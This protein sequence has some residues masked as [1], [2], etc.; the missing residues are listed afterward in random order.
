ME[1]R[2]SRGTISV[3]LGVLGLTFLP[4]LGSV[5]AILVGRRS[6]EPAARA[7]VILGWVGI[8]L[9]LLGCCVGAVFGALSALEETSSGP[10][11]VPTAASRSVPDPTATPRSLPEIPTVVPIQ[12]EGYLGV[13]CEDVPSGARVTDVVPDSPAEKAGLQEG[14]VIVRLDTDDVGSCYDLLRAVRSRPGERVVVT[15]RR[16]NETVGLQVALGAR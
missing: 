14:D 3:I 1:L 15:V 6:A 8:A 2:L 16:G 10:V 9:F 12:R 5:A 4:V 13:R 11:L 7:G